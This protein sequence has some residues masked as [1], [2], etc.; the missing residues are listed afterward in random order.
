WLPDS[1]GLLALNTLIRNQIIFVSYP[2]GK[3]HPVTRDTNDYSEPSIAADGRSLVTVLSERRW[4]TFLASAASLVASQLRQLTSGAPTYHLAWTRDGRLI[5]ES[6]SGLSLL[7]PTSGNLTAMD[8]P[9]LADSP[10][11]CGDGRY[12]VFSSGIGQG[13]KNLD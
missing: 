11:A 12:V 6:E 2:D 7:D 9:A 4:D 10:S 5:K 13:K 1:R 8:A 3:S